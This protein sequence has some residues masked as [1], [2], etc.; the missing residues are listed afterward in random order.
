MQSSRTIALGLVL[1]AAASAQDR[2]HEPESGIAPVHYGPLAEAARIQGDVRLT[3]NSGVITPVF[4]H[5]LLYRAALQSAEASASIVGAAKLTV[6]YHF[7]LVER[8]RIVASETDQ[9]RNVL[10]SAFLRML[11]R[12]ATKRVRT[13]HCEEAVAPANLVKIEGEV[14]EVWVYGR[15]RCLQPNE[16]TLGARITA[17]EAA[18]GNRPILRW[19]SWG[20]LAATVTFVSRLHHSRVPLASIQRQIG[21]NGYGLVRGSD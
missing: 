4:G 6:T 15:S 19:A 10:S 21:D 13:V 18:G 20:S 2:Q 14:I 11:G 3:I 9:K 1:L 7:V 12:T 5:P 16:V 17:D 8:P